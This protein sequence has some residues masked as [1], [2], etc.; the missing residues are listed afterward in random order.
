MSFFGFG[1]ETDKFK[2]FFCALE[3]EEG[4][5]IFLRRSVDQNNLIRVR[6]RRLRGSWGCFRL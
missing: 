1:T 5:I 3:E 6:W 4:L 2:V